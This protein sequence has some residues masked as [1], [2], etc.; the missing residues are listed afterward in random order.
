MAMM[1][2]TINRYDS[3]RALQ[4]RGLGGARFTEELL[5]T[6]MTDPTSCRW[7]KRDN[8]AEVFIEASSC[9]LKAGQW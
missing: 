4:E 8:V 3:R 7:N 9:V 5:T 1:K 6:E 2:V